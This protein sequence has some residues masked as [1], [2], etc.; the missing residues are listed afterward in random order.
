MSAIALIDSAPVGLR[1]ALGQVV[2]LRKKG[3]GHVE[4]T[5]PVAIA[6]YLDIRAGD[7]VE[8]RVVELA[9]GAHAILL[10]PLKVKYDL[11]TSLKDGLD[12]TLDLDSMFTLPLSPESAIGSR[13]EPFL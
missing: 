1:T 10:I 2:R 7:D 6:R 8:L 11:A 9:P 4:V 5:I 12:S 3:R 13:I